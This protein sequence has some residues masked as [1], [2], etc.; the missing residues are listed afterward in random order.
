MNV[1]AKP[2]ATRFFDPEALAEPFGVWSELREQ[3]PVCPVSRSSLEGV[4]FTVVSRYR[5]VMTALRDPDAFSNQLSRRFGGG[6]SPYE[7]TDEVK[8]VLADACP[9]VDALA[10]ADGDLHTR[11]RRMVLRGFSARRIRQLEGAIETLSAELVDALP[12]DVEI[13]FWPEVCNPLPIRVMAEILGVHPDD[14][15]RMK[16]WADAQVARLNGQASDDEQEALEIARTM[17]DFHRYIIGQIELR[18]QTPHDDFLGDLVANSAGMSL[19]ELV[20]VCSHLLI[21]G[22]ETTA[23]LIGSLLDHL[24]DRP[25]ELAALRADRSRIPDVV[26]EVLRMQAPIKLVYRIT[27]RDVELGGEIIPANTVV[28]LM[29]GSANLDPDAFAEPERFEEHRAGGARHIAFG[30]GPHL[31]PGATLA[32]SEARIFLETLFD[33][34]LEFHRERAIE[35]KHGSNLTFREFSEIPL[36][37]QRSRVGQPV[38]PP[39]KGRQA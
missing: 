29:L 21:G 23:S 32:R 10:F 33:R 3:A 7:D 16:T 1:P 22:A 6:H 2:A 24:V 38:G 34:S 14:A 36:V 19:V 39:D 4:E 26:E 18:Q 11:H 25:A 13:D 28:L 30:Y 9:Y 8:A 5:D 31:C 12:L 37:L 27:T 15:P 17:V 20:H 35:R